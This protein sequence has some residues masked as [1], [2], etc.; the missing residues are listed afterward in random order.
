M[1][2]FL[3][4]MGLLA[5]FDL[6]A[7]S[8]EGTCLNRPIRGKIPFTLKQWFEVDAF[9][10]LINIPLILL[11]VWLEKSKDSRCL[12]EC[13]SCTTIFGVCCLI[14]CKFVLIIAGA[15]IGWAD[16]ILKKEGCDYKLF[17]VPGK[18]NNHHQ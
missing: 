12:L 15:F 4:I 6:M 10:W 2:P 1:L 3:V 9:T 11:A 18:M 14:F 7:A 17:E 5:I 13:L 8:S 16:S